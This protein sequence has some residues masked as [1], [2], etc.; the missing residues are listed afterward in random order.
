MKIGG[1]I[2]GR[3]GDEDDVIGTGPK[4]KCGVMFG[5]GA[6][7]AVSTL[8]MG[9][10]AKAKEDRAGNGDALTVK[11]VNVRLGGAKLR[12]LG[13]VVVVSVNDN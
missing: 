4:A 3:M 9:V 10:T 7:L 5:Y 6:V 11:V 1:A 12:K 13:G 8:W 2:R